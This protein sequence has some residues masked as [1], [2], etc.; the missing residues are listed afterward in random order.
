M[1]NSSQRYEASPAIW[2]QTVLTATAWHRWT[3]PALTP[4]T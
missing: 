3:L 1:E 2:A 4:A